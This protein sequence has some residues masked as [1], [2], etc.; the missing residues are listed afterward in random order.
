MQNADK[1][2]AARPARIPIRGKTLVFV[3]LQRCGGSTLNN[4]LDLHFGNREI[5]KAHLLHR[6]GGQVKGITGHT[7]MPLVLERDISSYRLITGHNNLTDVQAIAAD[8]VFITFLRHP[9]DRVVSLY[10]YWRSHTARYA[11]EHHLQ[12]PLLAR[13]LTLA[14][15]VESDEPE[16]RY[17][18]NNG[19]ARQLVGGLVAPID[20]PDTELLLLAGDKLAKF[21]FVGI[22]E[23]FDLSV[24][25]LCHAL[26]W[27]PPD[28]IE[29]AN[30]FE[31][32]I[33]ESDEFEP[34][35]RETPSGT[36]L[37]RLTEKNR[38]D[39]ELYRRACAMLQESALATLHDQVESRGPRGGDGPVL[40]KKIARRL[41]QRLTDYLH[42]R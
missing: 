30:R 42:P 10:D 25:L 41:R 31:Q 28:E 19:M 23:W 36:T 18:V 13:R 35:A 14:E 20:L 27:T 16:A 33:R 4:L 11:Q 22:T 2:I 8:P 39:T 7:G 38:V 3:H 12:G 34:A 37:A 15:F 26:R 17:N 6:E 21:S 29:D 9:V 40:C 1:G 24:A 32:N 5:L